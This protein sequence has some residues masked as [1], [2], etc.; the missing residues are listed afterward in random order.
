MNTTQQINKALDE[1][2]ST[3]AEIPESSY[4]RFVLVYSPKKVFAVPVDQKHKQKRALIRFEAMNAKRG[5]TVRQWKTISLKLKNLIE[6]KDKCRPV[7]KTLP[8]MK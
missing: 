1:V 2:V 3:I 4:S 5:F 8:G 6:A 7:Q